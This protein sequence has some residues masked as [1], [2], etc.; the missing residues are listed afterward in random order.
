MRVPKIYQ[1]EAYVR[2][3]EYE[4]LM[5]AKFIRPLFIKKKCEVCGSKED[6]QLHHVKRFVDLLNETLGELNLDNKSI[7]EY[8]GKELKL[9]TNIMLGKQVKLSYINVCEECHNK[10]HL[11]ED[12]GKSG[13]GDGLEQYYKKL[14]SKKEYERVI[15]QE[16]VLEKLNIYLPNVVNLRLSESNKQELRDIINLKDTRGRSIKSIGT[17]NKYLKENMIPYTIFSKT[18]KDKK[19]KGIRFWVIEEMKV[20]NI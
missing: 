13:V 3:K 2:L 10:I 16:T 7:K 20:Q 14:R 11:V 18:G 9:I 19:R 12:G 5:F 17:L 8:S 15:N 4:R 1:E 6:I